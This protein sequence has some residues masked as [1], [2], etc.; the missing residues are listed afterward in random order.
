MREFTVLGGAIRYQVLGCCLL[1]I[2]FG[3]EVGFAKD[4]K[5]AAVNIEGTWAHTNLTPFERPPDI[6][7]RTLTA[8]QAKQIKAQIDARN[9]DLSRPAEPSLYFDQRAVEPIRGELRSA[10]VTDPSNGLIPGNE[11]FNARISRARAGIFTAFDGPEDRPPAERCVGAPSA[12][13]PIQMVP[14]GDLR[15]IIQTE[16]TIV[17]AAEELHEARVIRMN[18][19]H[20][21]A[22]ITSWLGDSIGWWEGKTLVIETTSFAASSALRASPNSLFLVSPYTV[23]LE[24]ITRVSDDELQYEFSVNDPTYYTQTWKGETRLH[25]S[26]SRMLEYACHEGN[27]SL[28]FALQDARALESKAQESAAVKSESASRVN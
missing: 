21:P 26:N 25:R 16:K 7:T 24:R 27:Y 17:I 4:T 13:P 19:K 12:T 6:A 1:S 10:I 11:A 22:A 9:D 15:Q 18:A 23:V 20:A 8:E 3:Q 2:V 5:D 28:R 14:A